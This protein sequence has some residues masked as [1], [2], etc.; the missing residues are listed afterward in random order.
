MRSFPT[1]GG[2][3]RA[4]RNLR[5]V[6]VEASEH[7]GPPRPTHLLSDRSS[8]RLGLRPGPAGGLTPGAFGPPDC[9]PKSSSGF[10][11]RMTR[12]PG[13]AEINKTAEWGGKEAAGRVAASVCAC[14]LTCR[15]GV[16]TIDR[17][18]VCPPPG[19]SGGL[20]DLTSTKCSA[21]T[22]VWWTRV[23]RAAHGCVRPQGGVDGEEP[24]L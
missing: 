13:S 11:R 1:H 10:P 7:Q 24:F 8:C 4:L 9:C 12:N 14:F 22:W 20:N 23:L 19:T 17:S 16:I 5:G 6:N 3:A 21:G 2:L 18:I 15:M